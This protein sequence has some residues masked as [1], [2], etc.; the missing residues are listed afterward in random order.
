MQIP[1]SFVFSEQSPDGTNRY[2]KALFIF[3]FI[4]AS[5]TAE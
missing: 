2:L 3:L 1:Y 4:I 5:F